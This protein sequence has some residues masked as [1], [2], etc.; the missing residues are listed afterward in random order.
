LFFT[1]SIHLGNV[2]HFVS[3]LTG[4]RQSESDFVCGELIPE[5]QVPG[6]F[7]ANNSGGR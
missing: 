7:T 2:F 4:R 1:E 6:L 3:V 5:S